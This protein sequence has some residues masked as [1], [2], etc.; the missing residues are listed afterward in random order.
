MACEGQANL[1]IARELKTSRPTVILWRKRFQQGGPDALTQEAP[2]RGRKPR[3]GADRIK[4]I[5]EA[6]L[7]TKPKA[8]TKPPSS[9]PKPSAGPATKAPRKRRSQPADPRWSA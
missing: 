6:T 7:Q 3:I 8:A 5:V 4:E 2:G 9:S 1:Q